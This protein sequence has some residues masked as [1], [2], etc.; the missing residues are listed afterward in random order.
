M[1]EIRNP[2]RNTSLPKQRQKMLSNARNKA[3]IAVFLMY[4][5]IKQCQEKLP[6][7]SVV[8]LAGGFHDFKKAVEVRK[9]GHTIIEQ[10]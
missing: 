4:D 9:D 10:L 1:Q 7:E 2:K 6:A 3:N 8:F 5:W